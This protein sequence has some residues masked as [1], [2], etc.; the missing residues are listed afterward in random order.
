MIVMD[1][2]RDF[3]VSFIS[4]PENMSIPIVGRT[5]YGAGFLTDGTLDAQGDAAQGL[6][7]TLHYAEGLNTPRDNA[8]RLAYAKAF[9]LQ[10]DFYA[11]QGYDAGLLM[12]QSL[13]KVGG[14]T[15]DRKAWTQ[16]MAA[17]QIDSPRGAWTFSKAHNP[18]QSIY[19]REVRDGAN[20][21]VSTAAEALADP[22]KGCTLL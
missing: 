14:N 2:L 15:R 4:K 6:L 1:K 12:A 3:N 5:L 19:L 8:F 13:D 9:K 22:A 11:V 16:A 7:T 21:V 17:E 20:V 10:P 18:I